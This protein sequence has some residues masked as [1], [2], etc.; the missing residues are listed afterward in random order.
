M[1]RLLR[2][3]IFTILFILQLY[4]FNTEGHPFIDDYEEG[5]AIVINDL[6]KNQVYRTYK[7]DYDFVTLIDNIILKDNTLEAQYKSIKENDGSAHKKGE[8][9]IFELKLRNRYHEMLHQDLIASGINTIITQEGHESTKTEINYVKNTMKI[10]GCLM[11]LYYTDGD[12]LEDIEVKFKPY[13]PKITILNDVFHYEILDF[14]FYNKEMVRNRAAF[15]G[16]L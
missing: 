6:I 12:T 14:I 5:N 13:L 11:D 1:L 8:Y 16:E 2:S 3:T 10:V 4:I 9:C 7:K 15:A